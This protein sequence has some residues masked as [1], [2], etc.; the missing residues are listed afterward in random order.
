MYAQWKVNEL[1]ANIQGGLLH[2]FVLSGPKFPF[3]LFSGT[4]LINLWDLWKLYCQFQWDYSP[5]YPP[6]YC[7]VRVASISYIL[8]FCSDISNFPHIRDM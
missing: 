1:L 3:D 4:L 7:L 2:L 6:S 5:L 8:R